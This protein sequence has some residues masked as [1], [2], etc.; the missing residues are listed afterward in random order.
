MNNEDIDPYDDEDLDSDWIYGFRQGRA[1][2]R[3]AIVAWLRAWAERN[4]EVDVSGEIERGEHVKKTNK[5]LHDNE[6]CKESCDD[7]V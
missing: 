5:T 2:E 1:V 4:G 6:T 7:E 3:E